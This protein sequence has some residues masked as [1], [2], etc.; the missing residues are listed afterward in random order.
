[1]D[2]RLDEQSV[3]SL[4]VQ[5]M[6]DAIK[7]L[8]LMLKKGREIGQEEEPLRL[9]RG[10][11]RVA[12][13][14]MGGS[15]IS[16]D[17]I[18]SLFLDKL[19]LHITVV[20]DYNLPPFLGKRT[21]YFAVSYSGDTEETLEACTQALKLGGQVVAVTSGGQLASLA[22]NSGFPLLLVPPG[23]QP[24]AALGFLF[25][26]ALAYMEK[27]KLVPDLS[28][29][30]EET[31]SLLE[32]LARR[33]SPEMPTSQNPAKQLALALEDKEI[34][35]FATPGIAAASALRWKT[36]INE[37]SKLTALV[38]FYPELD[39]NEIVAL[40]LRKR[41]SFLL[42][43]RDKEEHPRTVLRVVL[44]TKIIKPFLLGAE[45]IMSQG[46]SRLARLFSLVILGDF[47][48]YYLALLQGV[49]PTPVEAIRILKKRLSEK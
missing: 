41:N 4:D 48:S 11:D 9:I 7:N 14:G 34:I 39:H 45:E 19:P 29:Q 44:T 6:G 12:F 8:P 33:Y 32:E 31:F 2:T 49:D 40:S 37:N 16:G 26:A 10:I 43:L 15:A 38:D 24:R 27:L 36:Q 30:W 1:M 42:T 28:S 21:L 46:D 18:A 5:G 35:I 17:L 13:L 23:F 47:L 3:Y 20:R 25:G 22:R